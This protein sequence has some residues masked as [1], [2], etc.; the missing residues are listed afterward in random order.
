MAFKI[1]TTRE[2]AKE[3]GL[4]VLVHGPPG[5]GKTVL[6]STTGALDKTLIISAEAG[7]LSLRDY[8]IKVAKI[9]TIDDLRDAYRS[10]RDDEHP[11]EWVCLDSVSEIAEVVLTRQKDAN[12]DARAA[13][14]NLYDIML[15]L[16]KN[17]RDLPLNVYMSCKQKR[18]IE[19]I[20]EERERTKLVPS[21]PG[22]KL[23]NNISYLFDEVFALRV[24]K[25]ADGL[26]RVLQTQPDGRYEAK[27]RSGALDLMEPPSLEAIHKKIMGPTAV[28]PAKAGSGEV[29]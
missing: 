26:Y 12:K 8:D 9:E 24:E 7:L 11:F 17:F 16:L 23:T 20:D 13:Y 21:L 27:D 22:R 5:A 6:C 19:K 25:D 2:A 4:K 18:E 15:D 3:Q 28:G 14:G 10:L 29:A 1:T